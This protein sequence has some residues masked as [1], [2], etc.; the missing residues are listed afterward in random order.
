MRWFVA[1]LAIALVAIG[2]GAFVS[3]QGATGAQTTSMG[4]PCPSPMAGTPTA[5]ASPT[6]MASPSPSPEAC[7]SPSAG[8]GEQT[9]TM[10]DIAFQPTELTIPANTDVTITL[11]NTGATAHNFSIDE[12][13][14]S[15]DVD[16]GQT[17]TTTINA[18]AGTYTF[19]CNVPGHREAGMEGT[20]TVQ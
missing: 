10:V 5:M 16:P 6:M 7:P 3:G 12:L 18:D 20:L 1:V 8:G 15:V 19:Y 4:T 17:G 2:A 11:N 9:I 14:I 13:G